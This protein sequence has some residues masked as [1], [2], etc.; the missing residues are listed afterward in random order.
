MS[1]PLTPNEQL[2][3]AVY[4]LN[5]KVPFFLTAETIPSMIEKGHGVVINLSSIAASKGLPGAGAY[6]SSKAAI[7]QLTKIWAAEYG[8]AGVRVNA[9]VPGIVE[10]EG[11]QASLGGDRSAFVAL[12]PVGRVGRP[13]EIADAVAFLASDQTAFISGALLAVDGGTLAA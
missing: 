8:P 2:F 9:V 6:G 12:T 10:T 3:D 11:V 13:E 4:N 5:V 1:T 7:D